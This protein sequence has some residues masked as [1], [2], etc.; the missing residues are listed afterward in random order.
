MIRGCT[1]LVSTFPSFSTAWTR[2][3]GG[4]R[5]KKLW[6]RLLGLTRTRIE[7]VAVD[8]ETDVVV[9]SVR[10]HR[11]AQRRCGRCG[12]RSPWYDRGDGRRRRRALDLGTLQ[13]WLEAD[14]PRVCCRDHGPTVA[15]VP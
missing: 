8:D 12:L 6:Q 10:P 5:N 7:S 2:R 15:A 14:A 9:V 1:R 13:V 11:D 3:S 4:V